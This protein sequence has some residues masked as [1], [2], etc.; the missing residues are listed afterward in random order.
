MAA[1]SAGVGEGA[2]RRGG[3]HHRSA[4]RSS[5]VWLGAAA[6]LVVVLVLL[7][8][9]LPSS[10]AEIIFHRRDHLDQGSYASNQPVYNVRSYFD[11]LVRTQ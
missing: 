9:G 1:T 7:V 4:P 2:V 5:T 8:A 10:N 6:A 3:V 11:A